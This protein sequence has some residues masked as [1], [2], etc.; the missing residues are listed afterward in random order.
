MTTTLNQMGIYLVQ[1][2]GRSLRPLDLDPR[3]IKKVA[4]INNQ[5]LK[6]GKSE[7]P[8]S[9]RYQEYQKIFGSDVKFRCIIPFGDTKKMIAF[10]DHISLILDGY[11]ISNSGSIRKLEWMTGLSFSQAEQIIRDE[12]EFHFSEYEGL[13][14]L[15]ANLS[16]GQFAKLYRTP[17]DQLMQFASRSRPKQGRPIGSF[18]RLN[19]EAQ[20]HLQVLA[21][22]FHQKNSKFSKRELA[23]LIYQSLHARSE[24]QIDNPILVKIRRLSKER[25]RKLLA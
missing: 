2:Q 13:E 9:V 1:P 15:I 5:Y 6:F 14:G 4:K 23:D 24:E 18:N 19:E 8:L 3:R 20:E 21:S 17:L 12:Y 10:R 22:Q 16:V 7:R 11:K 25:L